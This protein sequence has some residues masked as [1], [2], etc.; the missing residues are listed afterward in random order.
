M[1]M[2]I[3]WG[4]YVGLALC[5]FLYYHKLEKLKRGAK[6]KKIKQKKSN[7]VIK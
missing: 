5:T 6:I 3:M 2:Y 7:N 4:L 1:L